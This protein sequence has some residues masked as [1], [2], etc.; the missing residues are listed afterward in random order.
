MKHLIIFGHPNPDSFNQA[1]VATYEDALKE[2]GHEVRIRDLYKLGFDPILKLSEMEGFKKGIYPDDVK[3]EQEHIK[4]AD[5][6][7][8]IYPIWWGGAPAIVKGYTERILSEGFAYT[9][10]PKG[11][12]SD[13]K[14]F[15]IN[16]L[17]APD[18]VYEKGGLYTSMNKV[19]DDITYQFA[20]IK[21][22]GHKYF[23]S[24]SVVSDQERKVM[25]QDVRKIAQEIC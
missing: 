22:I 11:L 2:K 16:T 21:G 19:L 9:D 24:V 1:I 3:T 15:T 6:I 17:D 12:L 8:F 18:E 5:I 7:T 13:K 23:A 14:A 10:G 4:W 25:L 20:A